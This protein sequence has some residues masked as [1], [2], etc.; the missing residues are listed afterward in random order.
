VHIRRPRVDY[1]SHG[2][3]WTATRWAPSSS[4][5]ACRRHAIMPSFRCSR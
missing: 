5:L 3:V 2:S 1:E 4:R